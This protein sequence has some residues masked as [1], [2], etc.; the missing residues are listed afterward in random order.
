MKRFAFFFGVYMG[1]AGTGL[2]GPDTI[3]LS[4]EWR[5][6]PDPEQIGEAQGWAAPETGDSEWRRILAGTRWE[7]QGFPDLDGT[8][9]YRTT[10]D[11][12]RLWQDKPVWLYLRSV[13]DACT[14][15]C[16]GHKIQT[17][18][19]RESSSMADVP[20][21]A[22][23]GGAV[24]YG[25]PNTIAIEAQDWGGSGGLW[26]LPCLL[27]SDLSTLPMDSFAHVALE[28]ETGLISV[29]VNSVGLGTLPPGSTARAD[30]ATEDGGETRSSIAKLEGDTPSANLELHMPKAAPGKFLELR[31]VMQDPQG[32]TVCGLDWH[33]RLE[34]PRPPAWPGVFAHLKV[35]NNFVTE[36]LTCALPAASAGFL[37]PRDGWVFFEV[38][39]KDPGPTIYLDEETAPL[40]WRAN[41]AQGHPE[42]MRFVKEGAHLLRSEGG[43]AGTL[44]V[45]AVPEL[46][47][48]Y[49]PATPHIAPYGPYDW[50]F[51][52]Q[53][54][55]SNVNT[56]VTTGGMMPGEFE[57]WIR[58]GRQWIGNATLPGLSAKTAPSEAEVLGVWSGVQ[59]ASAPGYGGIIVDEFLS[60]SAAH[61]RA[62]S[63]ALQKLHDTPAFSG[64]TFYAWCGDLFGAS[65]S[66]EFC[67]LNVQ[68]GYR[69][70]WEKYLAEASGESEAR[71]LIL[72]ELAAPMRAWQRQQPG[73]EGRIVMCLGYLCAFPETVNR[74]PAVDY[75][76]FMDLQ[77]QALATDPAFW[78]LYGVME[79][80]ASYADEESL[81]WAH[82]LFRHYCIEGRRTLLSD[83]PYRP[84]HLVN[85]DF[86]QG[87][88][89]WTIE[90]AAPGTIAAR[91][92]EG[93]SHL[94]GRYP[95]TEQG[96][97]FCW[98]KRTANAPN[99]VHQTVRNLVPERLYSLKLL[100][101][102]IGHLDVNQAVSLDVQL[103]G[104]EIAA[105]YGFEY[106]YPINYAHELAPY[107]RDHPAYFTFR[108]MVFRPAADTVE[109][110]I[111]DTTKDGAALGPAGQEIAF[112]FVE[113]QPF[114]EP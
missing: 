103:D 20:I 63:G 90:P 110:T 91:S 77:F 106:T 24:Q 72:H 95:G 84:N 30:A 114:I 49:Y 23:L 4:G 17:Y 92:M 74:D 62:W 57:A 51:V 3:D 19:K 22:F 21:L 101:S 61:Y 16:N 88:E 2:A 85:P 94:H 5:F 78:N 102:D 47:Y 69:F 64:R 54:V 36:L 96:D 81:R 6:R 7:D 9:W 34:W 104:A 44:V 100:S 8:A 45:R 29:S 14:V 48:C 108:R 31:M 50:K 71:A 87:L 12:P 39:A 112:N 105:P 111:S 52:T 37:N 15:Y 53:H 113:I 75:H 35:R 43:G 27:A 80:S 93:Y 42:A 70:A 10:V 89:G 28:T 58:E 32:A 46:A 83:W 67:R 25:A 11:I 33:Q 73:I 41:P 66:E 59:G 86:A 40:V 1:L 98:M 99:R 55:L 38:A 65:A 68:L 60:A 18:G 76:R 79:Y 82:K 107:T 13:N 97:R 56:I 109:L 26:K